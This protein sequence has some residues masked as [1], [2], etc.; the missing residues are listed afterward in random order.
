MLI[1][2]YFR[3]VKKSE[4]DQSSSPSSSLSEIQL[5]DPHGPLVLSSKIPHE[6]IAMA[7]A[8]ITETIME[9]KGAVTTRKKR[10]PYLHLTPA[11]R[12]QVGKRA[13]ECGVTN[14][15]LYGIMLKPFQISH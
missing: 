2:K 1:L 12:F 13:A 3:P 8:T 6:A 10:G 5:P 11:Q 9:S 15:T 4:T 7:N 14:I